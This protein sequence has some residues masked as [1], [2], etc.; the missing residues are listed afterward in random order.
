MNDLPTDRELERMIAEQTAPAQQHGPAEVPG[1]EAQG[2]PPP[3][4]KPA[5][6]RRG[7]TVSW[8]QDRLE[9]VAEEVAGA[10]H[11]AT[12][13]A[14]DA[15]ARPPDLSGI[16]LPAAA[17]RLQEKKWGA[18]GAEEPAEAAPA[19][20]PSLPLTQDTLA[21]HAEAHA[22]GEHAAEEQASCG[23]A[24]SEPISMAG[25]DDAAAPGMPGMPSGH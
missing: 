14:R 8:A 2:G 11:P 18:S 4:P 1:W 21:M 3:P 17:Q 23:T 6:G 15:A 10:G 16:S 25:P 13:D 22:A 24:K 9:P 7:K 5:A 19:H 20:A 12:P